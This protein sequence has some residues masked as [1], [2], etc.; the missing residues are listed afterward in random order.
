MATVPLRAARTRSIGEVINFLKS[1]Y[2]DVTVSKLR[3]LESQG[4]VEP[5]RSASGYRIF[6]EEDVRRIEYVLQEQRD[7]YLPLKVIKSKLSAWE[8]GDESPVS[9]EAGPPPEAYFATSGVSLT[10]AELMR[11]SGLSAH[12]LTSLIDVGILEPMK[13][14]DGTEVFRDHDLSIAR[15]AHRLLNHGLEVRHLRL[16]RLS[17]DRQTDLLGQ[18]VAPLLR[19]RNPEN[20]HRAAETLAD[21]AQAAAV[22]QESIARGRL[23]GLLER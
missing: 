17:A 12:Q 11:S 9:P 7:H 16:I 22:L 15:A 18:L 1:E 6:T 2:P 8:H 21:C 14:P 3:F 20:R 10:P 5:T 4:L 19:H 23:R 13:L